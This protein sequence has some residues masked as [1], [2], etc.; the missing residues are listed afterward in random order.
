VR[1]PLESPLDGE[2]IR[3]VAGLV[4]DHAEMPLIHN[5]GLHVLDPFPGQEEG[6]VHSNCSLHLTIGG[7]DLSNREE[8]SIAVMRTAAGRRTDLE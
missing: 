7:K 4:V 1:V 5:E 2:S 8:I 6:R 3:L